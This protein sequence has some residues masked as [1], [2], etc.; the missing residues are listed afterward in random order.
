[1]K[2]RSMLVLSVVVSVP[3]V[4]T[5]DPDVKEL[6]LKFTGDG[7]FA[8]EYEYL[9]EVLVSMVFSPAT[10][11]DL[12]DVS[13]LGESEVAWEI[14]VEPDFTFIDGWFTITGPN[15]RGSLVGEYSSFVMGDGTYTLGW[16]FT[17][18]TG[19]FEGADGTGLTNGVVNLGTGYAQ[20]EFSGAITVPKD[21]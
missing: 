13:H 1:M 20:F 6:G 17:G 5:A 11:V 8:V 16:D 2:L 4:V 9:G 15:G 3:L 21:D 12:L 18:G 14:R 10:G 19:R 7:Y